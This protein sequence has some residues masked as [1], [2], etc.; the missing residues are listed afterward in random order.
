[1]QSQMLEGANA[2]GSDKVQFL[3]ELQIQGVQGLI[4]KRHTET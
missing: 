2:I 3:L 4:Q 1:M